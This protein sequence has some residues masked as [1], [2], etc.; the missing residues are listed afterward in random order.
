MISQINQ[1]NLADDLKIIIINK[2]ILK[3][4]FNAFQKLCDENAAP[5]CF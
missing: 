5:T 4:D 1:N 3:Y 2:D